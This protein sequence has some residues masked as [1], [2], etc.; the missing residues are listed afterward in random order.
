[1]SKPA[2]GHKDA[3]YHTECTGQALDTVRAH[4]TPSEL[5]LFGACFCP[6][7]HRVWIALEY[8]GAPYQYREVDPYKKPADLLEL[9]P[10]GLV[11]ALKL[12]NGKGLAESTVILEYVDEKYG[13][14]KGGKTLLPPLSDAYERAVYR[15]AVDKANRNLIPSFYRYLQAQE[16]EKQLE[17]AKEFTSHLT[18]FVKSMS[19]PNP[20]GFWDGKSLSVVDCTVAPWLFRATNVLR[21]FRGFEPE[22]LLEGDVLERWNKWTGAVFGLDAFKAT[23]STDDLYLDSYVRYAQNRPMTS[24]V[25]DAINKGRGLP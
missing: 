11:P 9:N 17:G 13:G 2:P 7:V 16:V 22:K 3:V 20:E 6:F 5:T 1:M 21:H 8:L 10:K 24:Q 14:G 18:D 25:A 4:S 15:L 19:P 23:T 12:S